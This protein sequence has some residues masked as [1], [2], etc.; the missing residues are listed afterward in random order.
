MAKPGELLGANRTDADLKNV[1]RVD[2]FE[3]LGTDD[4]RK[5]SGTD[6]CAACLNGKYPFPI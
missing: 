2:T 3:Y 4:L 6:F 5:L 1:L